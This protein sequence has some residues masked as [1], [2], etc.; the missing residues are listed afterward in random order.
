MGCDELNAATANPSVSKELFNYVWLITPNPSTPLTIYLS[1]QGPSTHLT[2]VCGWRWR[3]KRGRRGRESKVRGEMWGGYN[4]VVLEE[5]RPKQREK[6]LF[7]STC[8]SPNALGI[9]VPADQ[10]LQTFKGHRTLALGDF[11]Y[12]VNY[13]VLTHCA[14]VLSFLPTSWRV[15]KKRI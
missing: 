9:T 5:S 6:A 2:A 3:D 8:Y 14:S 12:K 10:L 15:G 11:K 7:S 4:A 1:N 13:G